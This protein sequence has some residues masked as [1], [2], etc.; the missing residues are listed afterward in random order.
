MCCQSRVRALQLH[1]LS[2][3]GNTA[4]TADIVA[5]VAALL[6]SLLGAVLGG[7]LGTRYHRKVD[8]A[9]YDA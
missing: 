2:I 3:S 7:K 8:R 4:T 9:G 6:A 1:P 5:G